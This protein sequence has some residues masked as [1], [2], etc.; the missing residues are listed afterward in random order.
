MIDFKKDILSVYPQS[1]TIIPSYRCNAE[2]AECCFESNPRIKQRL[3]L[4]EIIYAIDRARVAFPALQLIV[5]SGGEVFLLKDDLYKAISHASGH[6]L[7][8]RCVTNAFWGKSKKNA[9]T[10]VEKLIKANVSEINISTGVDHQKFVPLE[11]VINA[12]EELVKGGIKTLITVEKDS[13]QTN[14][15]NTLRED[16]RI[17][18]IFEDDPELLFIQCNSWMPF[19]ANYEARGEPAGLESLTDGCTQVMNNLVVTPYAKVAACCGLTFEHIP[20]LTVGDLNNSTIDQIF[21]NVLQDFLK[22]WMHLDG[23]GNIMRKL[24]GEEINE[25]LKDIRHICQ[26][27]V[28]LHKHPVVRERLREGYSE[29]VPDVLS[30]F[31]LKVAVRRREVVEIKN[32]LKNVV[33]ERV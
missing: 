3:S 15:L 17:R 21:D 23:P 29:F 11:S 26:A 28:V 25:E 30:R 19:H 22:I 10:V 18:K 9:E 32:D 33:L 8:V 7:A 27:C 1:I 20:E 13:V 12:C 4:E 31:A 6:G 5:F 24:F 16:I 2:C 14:C